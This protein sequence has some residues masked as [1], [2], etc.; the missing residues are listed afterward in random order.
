MSVEKS[1]LKRCRDQW[2]VD[3]AV[4]MNIQVFWNTTPGRLVSSLEELADIIVRIRIV[5]VEH[6]N[7]DDGGSKS[8]RNVSSYIPID[9]VSYPRIL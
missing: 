7:P 6:L 8:F 2:Q 9:V 5:Q 3:T 1:R 4:L